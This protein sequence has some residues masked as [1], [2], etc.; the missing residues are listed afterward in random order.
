MTD[1]DETPEGKRQ[2][3]EKKLAIIESR[4]AAFTR[5]PS[6]FT[7]WDVGTSLVKVCFWI[8]FWSIIAQCT[9]DGCIWSPK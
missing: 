2:E 8:A 9:C 1:F 5:S 4:K 6:W 3:H 7:F